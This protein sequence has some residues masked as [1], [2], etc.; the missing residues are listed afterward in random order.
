MYKRRARS[1]CPIHTRIIVQCLCVLILG[2]SVADLISLNSITPPVSLKLLTL[3]TQLRNQILML[4]FGRT[5]NEPVD[6]AGPFLP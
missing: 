6:P 5:Q 4:R 3:S 2:A 1:L